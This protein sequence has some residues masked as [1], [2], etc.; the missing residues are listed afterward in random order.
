MFGNN[1]D[2]H[3]EPM[4]IE[5]IAERKAAFPGATL[6]LED[7]MRQDGQIAEAIDKSNAQHAGVIQS[8]VNAITDDKNYRQILKNTL[9]KSTEEQ[10]KA[11]YALACCEMTGAVHAKKMLLDRLTARSSGINGFLMH[12]ALE[13]LT[14]TT[15]TSQ[16]YDF[17]KRK[18]G[19]RDSN[20]PISQ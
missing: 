1:G 13:A 12:E 19:H 11:V 9:W 7:L 10:D 15:F 14:H 16:K 4:S 3:N 20:S 17:T 5:Q 6:K 18:N 2:N 8:F